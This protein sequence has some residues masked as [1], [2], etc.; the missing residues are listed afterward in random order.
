MKACTTTI[1][2]T[3]ASRADIERLAN[4]L[5]ERNYTSHTFL[6]FISAIRRFA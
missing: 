2:L 4:E 1:H 6:D 5:R 3:G